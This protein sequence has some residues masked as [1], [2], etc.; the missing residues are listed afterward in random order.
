MKNQEV[1]WNMKP[2]LACE[3]E[4]V[5]EA[6]SKLSITFWL[7][8]DAIESPYKHTHGNWD[9]NNNEAA[10]KRCKFVEAPKLI[11]I[12]CGHSHINNITYKRPQSRYETQSRR[13]HTHSKRIKINTLRRFIFFDFERKNTHNT[14][15]LVF[16]TRGERRQSQPLRC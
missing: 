9:N 16:D 15:H 7:M 11:K 6:I 10:R 14:N 13:T 5:I 12:N 4:W 2:K 3:S 8:R 1:K